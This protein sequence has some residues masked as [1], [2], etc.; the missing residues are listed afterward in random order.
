MEP[1]LLHAGGVRTV[2]IHYEPVPPSRSQRRIDQDSTRLAT[3]E[4]QRARSGFRIGARHRRAQAAVLEREAELVAGYAELEYS[5]FL[6]VTASDEEQLHRDCAE[7]E[8]A[9]AQAGLELR[10]LDGR[11]DL[12]FVC[13]LP[14]G[15]GLAPRRF[16]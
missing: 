11:H 1:L 4:E 14:V 3:D 16:A 13:S 7:Y 6:T 8:Q 10:A 9:A 5:G 12:G 15:R 2:A